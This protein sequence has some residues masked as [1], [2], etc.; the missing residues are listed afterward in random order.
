[1]PNVDA[2]DVRSSVPGHPFHPLSL[3]P[4]N[5]P[6]LIVNSPRPPRPPPTPSDLKPTISDFFRLG[7]GRTGSRTAADP[8]RAGGGG[9]LRPHRGQHG[10]HRRGNRG[11]PRSLHPARGRQCRRRF[12]VARP[13]G[14]TAVRG[15]GGGVAGVGDVGGVRRR[16]GRRR[17]RGFGG[18]ATGWWKQYWRKRRQRRRASR[19]RS[20]R[21]AARRHR[22]GRAR[23]RR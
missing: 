10:R 2:V 20:G 8:R 14:R 12:G 23:R 16:H 4:S 22:Y 11:H 18:T 6:V 5:P 7:A 1:M 13:G 9:L 19:K 3:R 17:G 15:D 21:A